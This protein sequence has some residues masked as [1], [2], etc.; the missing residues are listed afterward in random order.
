MSKK[1][2]RFDLKQLKEVIDD[3]ICD[4]D[5]WEDATFRLYQEKNYF[6]TE[7]I[8]DI[9]ADEDCNCRNKY[10]IGRFKL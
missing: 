7:V 5:N 3:Y 10:V 6:E 4:N 2:V 9:C 8:M 1:C